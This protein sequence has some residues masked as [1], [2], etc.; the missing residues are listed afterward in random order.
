MITPVA[1]GGILGP[2]AGWTGAGGRAADV[3]G[4]G[5]RV[6]AGAEGVGVGVVVGRTEVGVAVEV[7]DA[8]GPHVDGVEVNS[9]PVNGPPMG[10][11]TRTTISG[12]VIAD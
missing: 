7:A 5:R 3:R 9:P 6:T 4:S 1:A 12:S 8:D 2:G 11:P 10:W